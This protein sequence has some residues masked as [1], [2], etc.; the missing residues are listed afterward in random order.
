MLIMAYLGNDP[1]FASEPQGA[2]GAAILGRASIGKAAV[3]ENYAVVRADGHYVTIG[4]DFWLGEHATVHIAHGVYPTHIGNNVT[5][6]R[7]SVI[8][9]C[10]VGSNCF[11]G[12][13]VVILDG[14]KVSDNVAI[15]NGAIVFP[16]SKLQG[17][18]LF[19]G[20]PAEPVRQ[21]NAGELEA[22]QSSVRGAPRKDLRRGESNSV[23]HAPADLFFA[24]TANANGS[25]VLGE[26][27]GVW[28]GCDLDAGRHSI[29]VGQNTNIQ[30]NTTIRCVDRSV[31]IGRE[32][33]IG[34]NVTMID[35]EIADR[36]LIGIGAVVA[37]GTVVEEDV[38]L[39]AGGHTN[40]GQV[41]ESGWF[42][43]GNPARQISKLDD[44]KRQII[45]STWPVYRDYARHFKAEQLTVGQ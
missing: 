10:D 11:I 15:A 22:L 20:Q 9:A 23:I 24:V 26:G 38:L 28:F 2:P 37:P 12:A 35:C 39:G 19:A 13:D 17:G 6:S 7:N 30:D 41:L 40:P 32:S 33:T 14:S 18:W 5:A 44:G 43:G 34:H 27:V 36:S 3:L 16:R 29:S 4:D 25:L 42:Y 31:I 8:H 45:S 21:L 1:K